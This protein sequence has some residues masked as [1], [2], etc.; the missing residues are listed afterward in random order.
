[1]W[2]YRVTMISGRVL[3]VMAYQYRINTDNMLEFI[4]EDG[5]LIAWFKYEEVAGIDIKEAYLKL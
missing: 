4:D 2:S 5:Q 1:M 3:S